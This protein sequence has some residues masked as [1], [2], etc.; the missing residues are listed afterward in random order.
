V[1]PIVLFI[2]LQRWFMKGL[3]AGAIKL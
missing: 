1:P 3:T 2:I